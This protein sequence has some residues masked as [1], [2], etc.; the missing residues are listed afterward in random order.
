MVPASL[1][2]RTKDEIGVFA[3]NERYLMTAIIIIASRND[4]SIARVHDEAWALF[5]VSSTSI[6]ALYTVISAA[7]DQC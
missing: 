2:P 7:R 5:R 1:I 4:M 3:N 6:Y